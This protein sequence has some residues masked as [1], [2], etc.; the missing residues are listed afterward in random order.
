MPTTYIKRIKDDPRDRLEVEIGDSKQKDFY[1]QLKIKRWDNEVNVSFRLL[2][3]TGTQVEEDGKIKYK[4][5]KREAHFY[6]L[7]VSKEHPKGASEFGVILKEKPDTNVIEFSIKSKGLKFLHQPALTQKEK[8]DGCIRPESIVGSYAVY[9]LEQKINYVG[10]KLYKA[11]KV[12]HI[13]KPKMIDSVG[14]ETWGD[15]HIEN[16]LLSVTIPQDFLDNAVYPVKHAAGLT[17]GYMSM[18][19]SGVAAI[20]QETGGAFESITAG[21]PHNLSEAGTLVSIHLALDSSG[22]QTVDVFAALYRENS[23]GANSHDL[24]VGIERQ[25]VSITT[26]PTFFV[27]TASSEELTTDDYIIAGISD[28]SQLGVFSFAAILIQGDFGAD[29]DIDTYNEATAGAGGYATRK[30]EDPWTNVDAPS[31][32]VLSAYATYAPAVE[33]ETAEVSPVTLTFN[34]PAVTATYAAVINAVVSP[35]TAVFSV[36]AVTATYVYVVNA[37][38]SAVT[39]VFSVSAV[40]AT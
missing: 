39:A 33:P 3:D 18:G 30:A 6:E 34:I 4:S 25:D 29:P 5:A 17:F 16:D 23:A 40:T 37:S 8:N 12:G 27:F 35:V 20:A 38:V 15:L 28:G 9:C 2:G 31:D 22:N 14:K 24:V 19:A 13:P 1:P 11:S 26:T 7:P 36:S 10:G 21:Q 32:N